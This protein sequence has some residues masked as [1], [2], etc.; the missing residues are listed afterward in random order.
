MAVL[1]VVFLAALV[2]S[3]FGFGDAL[4]AMPFLVVLVGL[5]T[6]T[7]LMALIAWYLQ[8]AALPVLLC[9]CAGGLFLAYARIRNISAQPPG[10]EK[11]ARKET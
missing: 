6:A 4:I 7:P 8:D 11:E 3:T 1:S 2:R 10:Q 5:K 9:I